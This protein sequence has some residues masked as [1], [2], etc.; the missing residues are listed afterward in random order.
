MSN[1]RPKK[2]FPLALNNLGNLFPGFG[3]PVIPV[4][5]FLRRQAFHARLPILTGRPCFSRT[6]RHRIP[7]GAGAVAGP[8]IAWGTATGDVEA[9]EAE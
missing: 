2:S 9:D 8:G 4:H 6:G 3:C 5:L 7:T 1:P